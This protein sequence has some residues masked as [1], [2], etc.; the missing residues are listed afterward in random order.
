[1]V[2]EPLILE[3][4]DVD[5]QAPSVYLDPKVELVAGMADGD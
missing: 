1:M 2:P 5:S 4:I 3:V